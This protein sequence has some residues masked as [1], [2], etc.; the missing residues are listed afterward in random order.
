MCNTIELNAIVLLT[1]TA[2]QEM[3]HIVGVECENVFS[4][5]LDLT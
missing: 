4:A 3:S 2:G 5:V 1:A